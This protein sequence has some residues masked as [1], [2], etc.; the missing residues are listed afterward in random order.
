MFLKYVSMIIW[1]SSM[2]VVISHLSPLILL[3]RLFSCWLL[4]KFD[5]VLPI[6]LLV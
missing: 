5:T 6:L 2:S 4:V 3:I 1:I